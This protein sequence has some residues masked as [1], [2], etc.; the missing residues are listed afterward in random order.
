MGMADNS[1][2]ENYSKHPQAANSSQP[3]SRKLSGLTLA[4]HRPLTVF[5]SVELIKYPSNKSFKDVVTENKKL[6]N[7]F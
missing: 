3:C 1:Q 5:C 2:S 4:T 6:N 7:T